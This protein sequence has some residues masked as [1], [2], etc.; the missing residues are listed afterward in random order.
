ME[1][2]QEFVL[3]TPSA[4]LNVPLSDSNSSCQSPLT[5]F[6]YAKALFDLAW[7]IAIACIMWPM[8]SLIGLCFVGRLNDV[9]YVD[10]VSL[11]TSWAGIFAFS[12]QVGLSNA[13]DTLISQSFGKKEFAACG[14]FFNRALLIISATSLA[15][16]LIMCLSGVV[17]S[18][19][20]I[21]AEVVRLAHA[22]TLAMIP[23]IILNAPLIVLEHFLVLQGVVYPE[24]LLQLAN[25]VLYPGYCY[26]F[27][28]GLDMGYLGAAAAKAFSEI[29]YVASLAVYVRVTGCS[30]ECF[31][32]MDRSALLG[33]REYMA[34]GLPTLLMTCLEWWAWEIMNLFSGTLGV[35]QLAAN[36][37]V[38]NLCIFLF[39]FTVG[40]SGASS[41]LVGKSLGEGKA[42]QARRFAIVGSG[43]AL[44]SLFVT[45]LAMLAAKQ[46][47]ERL[48]T[49][50]PDV[51]RILDPL[52]YVFLLQQIFD[53]TQS[54]MGKIIIATG[55]QGSA[56]FANLICYY[57]IMLPSAFVLGIFANLGV[58]GIW[59]G[60]TIG[61][62]AIL[63]WY[64]AI[65]LRLDWRKVV[66]D[67]HQRIEDGKN[68]K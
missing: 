42:E 26:F 10:A 8:H 39:I 44:G 16:C 35:N 5:L 2:P 12:I 36:S 65:L 62:I 57:V 51:I 29:A 30:K 17:F 28:I 45:A 50:D 64:S 43:M 23:A 46:I 27:I 9:K 49:S 18:L 25:T 19:F 60:C 3:Q 48:L 63:C 66:V 32:P 15:C 40:F 38:Y 4:T 13:L 21:D 20:G 68:A 61:S 59:M 54:V 41:T 31:V 37:T 53:N 52:M 11:G 56:S 6:G 14:L 22:F 67:S 33:W 58:C 1:Q 7:P 34:L 55:Y 24:M 47:F